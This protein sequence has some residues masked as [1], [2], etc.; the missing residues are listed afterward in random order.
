[1]CCVHLNDVILLRWTYSSFYQVGCGAGGGGVHSRGGSVHKG[2]S[3][4][5]HQLTRFGSCVLQAS[6][7]RC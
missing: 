1:M 7:V 3:N 5:V 2:H 6:V 4:V